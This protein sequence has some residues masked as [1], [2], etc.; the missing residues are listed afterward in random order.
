MEALLR[1]VSVVAELERCGI[2]FDSI[3][4]DEIK[5]ACPFHDDRAPSCS[6]NV[7][8][9]V[10]NCHAA[11]CPNN[12]GDFIT[13]MAGLL[14]TSRKAVIAELTERY[15][16]A[17][18]K[19][20][21]SEFV[22]RCHAS[23][24]TAGSL[25]HELRA[26]GITDDDI[27]QYRLGAR[28]GRV[29]IPVR[30]ATGAVINVR[31]YLPGAPG[32]E[33]MRN[34]PKCGRMELFPV[35]QLRYKNMIICGGEI[36]AI[37]VAARMNERGY[38]AVTTTGGEGS[39]DARF[40]GLFK[41]KRVWVCMDIDDGGIK[42]TDMVAVQ[43]AR[44]AESVRA[45][46]LPLNREAYPT[47]D[48]NDYFGQEHATADDF[49]ALLQAAE[50]WTSP[51]V[52]ERVADG[53]PTE[54]PLKAVALAEHVGRRITTRAIICAMD[55]APYV[56]PKDVRCD[57]DR[58]QPE[59]AVCP[60]YATHP[61][62]DRGGVILTVHSESPAVLEMVGATKKEMHD[63]TR[64]G[65]LIPACKSVTFTPTS[66]YNVD[67]VRLTP[68]LEITED[69]AERSMYPAFCI[70][71]GLE[72]NAS[73]SLTGRS[74]PSPRTQQSV[75]LA[76]SA[77]PVRDSLSAYDPSDET[78]LMLDL[79]RPLRWTV[80]HIAEKLSTL[81]A[82]L[83]ANVTR[84]YH[85]PDMHLAIDLAY[86][87][88]LVVDFAGQQTKG[89]VEVLVIGDSSQG[90]TEATLG[91]IRHYGLGE[92]ADCKNASTAGLIGGLQQ[93][94]TRWFVTWGVIPMHDRRL[95]VLEELKGASHEVISRLTDMRSS[96]IAELP[97]I[98]R[99]RTHSRTRLVCLSNP[100]SNRSMS[101]F[102][103][104]V[105]AVAEL[106][107]SPE[108]V[109]RFDLAIVVTSSQVDLASINEAHKIRVPHA[110]S[111]A[112]CR[113]LVLWAWTR[114][115]ES[116]VFEPDAERL[117]LSAAAELGEEFSPVIPLI[118]SG[119]TRF[120]LARLSAAL[121]CRTFSTDTTRRRAVVRQCHAEFIVA[122]IR[123]LYSSPECG[124]ADF[125]A[126][127]N[128]STRLLEPDALRAAIAQT[129]FPRDFVEQLLQT[130]EIELRDIC[131]WCGWNREDGIELLSMLVRKHAL[132]REKNG[133]R[134]SAAF[135]AMLKELRG[136]VAD[137]PTYVEEL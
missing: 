87:S 64:R 132:M 54:V 40:T 30:D 17:T 102:N 76:S 22:E 75:L 67:D 112:A 120:K 3:G 97:K 65:L 1:T 124:Y 98:E 81:Y 90:K 123:R 103:F 51:T 20:I 55:I 13:F 82:D 79:F 101:G 23:I 52:P 27:R 70:G 134:K 11:G 126:A 83:A 37:A 29:A 38:G 128:R 89:W 71:H 45:V 57:C 136:T 47:G 9:R 68:Q 116:V 35:D 96:G 106:M 133:Y 61:N 41:G 104:G 127:A 58:A 5:C 33:K 18:R 43:V 77:E 125:S 59:C 119:G 48:V 19:T 28:D 131:D 72:S 122:M 32:A 108:D 8:K 60:V 74:F 105:E 31:Y 69:A 49:D 100:R 130:T 42:A 56:V 46:R 7:A 84:I 135:I 36:K 85:R 117:I 26:R 80:E 15:G 4:N 93:V 78:L 110:H 2:K 10:F 24:W 86:H 121:A 94:G 107:G 21:S 16:V 129:P 44:E 113:E 53:E 115:P 99:R 34:S 114:G 39:W 118:D 92:R 50:P 88:P 111:A 66:W 14:K 62:P 25:L 6:I 12:H 109:R 63:A 73:Y 91:L 95:V 137:R